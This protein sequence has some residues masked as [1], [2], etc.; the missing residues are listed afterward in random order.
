MNRR[1]IKKQI[2]RVDDFKFK[3]NA[4]ISLKLIKFWGNFNHRNSKSN[5]KI[6]THNF[7]RNGKFF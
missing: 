6:L 5:M 1:K 3:K 2:K 7:Y 4:L